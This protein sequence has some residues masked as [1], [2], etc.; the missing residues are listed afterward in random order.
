MA[1]AVLQKQQRVGSTAALLAA[2]GSVSSVA[3]QRK[4]QAE[5]VQHQAVKSMFASTGRTL[6]RQA[7][8]NPSAELQAQQ[9]RANMQRL[10]QADMKFKQG[11][12]SQEELEWAADFGAKA[13]AHMPMPPNTKALLAQRVADFKAALHGPQQH[14]TPQC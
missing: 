7:D 8:Q 6:Q 1:Q 2:T 5:H 4:P 10:V 12:I 11:T 14:N 9:R 3:T 13:L